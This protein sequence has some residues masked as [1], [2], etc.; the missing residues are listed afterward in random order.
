MERRSSILAPSAASLPDTFRIPSTASSLLKSLGRLSRPS[1]LSLVSQ[2]LDDRNAPACRPYLLHDARKRRKAAEGDE[3]DDANPYEPAASI[4]ELRD[5]YAS[6]L[7]RKGG[8]RE[9]V[10]RILEGDWRHGLTLRQLA[11][12]D[13]RYIE[14]HPASGHRWTALQLVP[15]RS[16]NTSRRKDN[17]DGA[18]SI[19]PLPQFHG[20]TFLKSIQ[21]NISPLV[22]AH[23]YLSRS[24][25][26]PLTFVRI[27]IIDS[28][29]QYPRQSAHVFTDAS[30][31]IYL[32]FPDSSPYI[33]SSLFSIPAVR[34]A[35]TFSTSQSFL[36]TDTQTL[37][38]IVMDAIPKA[39]SRPQQRLSLKPTSLTTKSLHTLLT[40]RGP[41]RTNAANGAFTV[42]ADAVVEQSPL[43]PRLSSS[44]PVHDFAT[45]L[46][47]D[48]ASQKANMSQIPV[49]AKRGPQS[50]LDQSD[51]AAKRKRQRTILTR[52]G[53]NSTG[54]QPLTTPPLTSPT[55]SIA[56]TPKNPSIEKLEI[57]LLDP[58]TPSS[59]THKTGS[60]TEPTISLTFSGSD[61]ISGFQQLA[62][63]G[64]VDVER[65]P[66]WM[67]GEE[68]GWEEGFA[69]SG[70]EMEMHLEHGVIDRVGSGA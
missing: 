2:W 23:Y 19:N 46:K 65:I 70:V 64:V 47:E 37:R 69:S 38:R 20:A 18:E 29:Y 11:M 8:K 17:D 67:T 52:F 63:L 66:T 21:T 16:K 55:P 58:I 13:I 10:D 24:N 35:A 31:L 61:V 3:D 4:D 44:V 42:F 51:S 12:A 48:P 49:S 68:G 54:R 62:E 59:P 30:R 36:M 14:D 5:I 7:E 27:F 9:V 50:E 45:S 60:S 41:W 34:S 25:S 1:L 26:L 33:Y 15:A 32:A 6:F 53:T 57:R 39:L 43:D 40:L 28:P 22:K 56:A